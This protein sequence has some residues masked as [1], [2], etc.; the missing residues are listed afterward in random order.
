VPPFDVPPLDVPAPLLETVRRWPTPDGAA[1]LRALPERVARLAHEWELALGPAFVPGGET[2]YVC[3]ASTAAGE[4]AVLKVVVPHRE[5]RDE[6]RA[7]A[8]WNGNGAVRLWRHAADDWALL[9]ER[10]E[11]GTAL[12]ALTDHDAVLD[13]GADVLRR[14]WSAP[15][16]ERIEPLEAVTDWFADLVEERQREQGRP[17]PDA[18]VGEAVELLRELPRTATHRVVLHHDFH[19]GNV[20]AAARSPWLAIDPK[21][22]V[23]DPAFDPVQ[24][25]LQT[26]DPLDDEDPAA[27]IRYRILR[28]ADRLDIDADRLR[29]WGLARCVEWSLSRTARSERADAARDAEHA[30]LFHAVRC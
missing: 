23:G 19:P 4:A 3:A 16:D 29:G 25:V 12:G 9:L 1:W 6:A 24:L 21:P 17:L 5:A 10:C 27:T 2:A 18:L 15:P 7:L 22:Q 13:A 26:S 14:L 30:R 11:P 8:A 20:L 28:L